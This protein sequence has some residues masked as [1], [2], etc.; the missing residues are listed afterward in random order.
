MAFCKPRGGQIIS[1]TPFNPRVCVCFCLGVCHF[2]AKMWC[3]LSAI[4]VTIKTPSETP[5][6]QNSMIGLTSAMDQG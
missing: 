1:C 3:P 2:D 6:P 5:V 4:P